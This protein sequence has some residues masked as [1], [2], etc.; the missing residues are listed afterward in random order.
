MPVLSRPICLVILVAGLVSA[1]ACANAGPP[2][3]EAMRQGQMPR[4]SASDTLAM[5]FQRI[6][7]PAGRSD[8]IGEY[9]RACAT[10]SPDGQS[11][12]GIA[13]CASEEYRAW[14]ARLEAAEQSLPED[15]G[16]SRDAWLAQSEADCDQLAA[17]HEN[18]DQAD[19]ARAE[20]LLQAT[21]ERTIELQQ[22]AASD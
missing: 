17:Q 22:Q 20:C 18:A 5:C 14:Q 8:C 3:G 19:R 16:N 21:A 9:T 12:P 2:P 6:G 7:D 13:R 15:S 11:D 4:L 1:P 10:L